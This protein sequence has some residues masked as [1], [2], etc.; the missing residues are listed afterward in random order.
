MFGNQ[1]IASGTAR[2]GAVVDE[3][4]VVAVF[5]D[6]ITGTFVITR[7]SQ[8]GAITVLIGPDVMGVAGHDTRCSDCQG[9]QWNELFHENSY[10]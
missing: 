2:L 6:Q 4:K 8:G 1:Q 10:W 7:L 3:G 5:V 9:E